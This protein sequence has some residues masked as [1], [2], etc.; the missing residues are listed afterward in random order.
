MVKEQ[1]SIG[2]VAI[3]FV[4]LVTQ[5]STA[6]TYPSTSKFL[7]VNFAVGDAEGSVAFSFNYDKGLGSSRPTKYECYPF[8]LT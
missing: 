8:K 6:Q 4:A 5:F 2:V 3:F 7:D 1:I